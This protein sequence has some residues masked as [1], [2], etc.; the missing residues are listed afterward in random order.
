MENKTTQKAIAVSEALEAYREA[1]LEE[2][3][4]IRNTLQTD[5]EKLKENKNKLTAEQIDFVHGELKKELKN[6]FYLHALTGDE[7][8][9]EISTQLNTMVQS[10]LDSVIKSLKHKKGLG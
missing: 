7:K 6:H 4:E 9:A 1:V 3:E 10:K 2:K 5:I 8:T